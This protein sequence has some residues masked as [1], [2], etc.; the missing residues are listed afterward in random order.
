MA[1][2]RKR[3]KW[4]PMT[5]APKDGTMILVT[6]TPNGEHWNVMPACWM[7]HRA[8]NINPNDR[9]GDWWGIDVARWHPSE[10]PLPVRWK[11]LAITPVCWQPFPVADSERGLRRRLAKTEANI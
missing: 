5:S 4:L 1:A 3:S 8:E 9:L 7:A 11:P 10:G 2:K 6:E